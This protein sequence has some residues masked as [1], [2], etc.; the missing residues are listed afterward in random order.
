V[1]LSNAVLL[2]VLALAFGCEKAPD[3]ECSGTCVGDGV[4]I[5]ADVCSEELLRWPSCN[6]PEVVRDP[7]VGELVKVVSDEDTRSTMVLSVSADDFAV[8]GP[9]NPAELGSSVISTTDGALLGIV[10]AYSSNLSTC[11]TIR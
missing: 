3:K 5:S 7:V 4:A 6:S 2:L 8:G 9:P 1:N 11:S 10:Q